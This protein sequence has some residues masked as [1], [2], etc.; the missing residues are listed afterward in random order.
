MIMYKFYLNCRKAAISIETALMLWIAFGSLYL[1]ASYFGHAYIYAGRAIETSRSLADYIAKWN[2]WNLD[3]NIYD[4]LNLPTA[5]T[6]HGN[7]LGITSDVDLNSPWYNRGDFMYKVYSAYI[8]SNNMNICST[9][10]VTNNRLTTGTYPVSDPVLDSQ[11]LSVD[12]PIWIVLV[13]FKVQGKDYSHRA[14]RRPTGLDITLT[15]SGV[16][17]TCTPS[18]AQIDYP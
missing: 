3:N 12:G 13:V 9:T 16:S 8:S 17:Y 15:K 4:K 11:T 10:T 2:D 6:R 14:V 18:M 5:I 7:L 1:L